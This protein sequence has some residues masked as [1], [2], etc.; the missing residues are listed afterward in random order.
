M[1][2][3]TKTSNAKRSTQ[4]RVVPTIVLKSIH[5][6]IMRDNKNATITTKKMR[7]RLRATPAM[8]AIHVA[9][10]SWIFTQ[11]QADAVRAMFDPSFAKKIERASKRVVKAPVVVVAPAE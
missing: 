7:V 3:S 11:S 10:A 2:R 1:T 5:D 4:S 8:K 9:N 6:S